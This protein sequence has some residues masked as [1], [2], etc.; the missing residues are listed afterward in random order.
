MRFSGNI[1]AKL[2]AKGRVALPSLF[3]KT[4]QE[5]EIDFMLRRDIYQPC[6]VV[7]PLA[8]WESEVESLR[9]RIN[10]WNREEAMVFR[11]FLADA[12]PI[13]LDAAGRLLLSKKWLKMAEIERDVRFIGADDRIEIWNH[14]TA[15][16]SFLPNPQFGDTLE[17]IMS[18]QETT[19]P[20]N[21]P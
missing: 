14:E 17:R 20:Q 4:L 15:A 3:R 10:R 19:I 2:D 7:Y 12:E 13:T 5:G 6:L 11:Q 18:R 8:S 1:V 9:Q 21:E 16:Q